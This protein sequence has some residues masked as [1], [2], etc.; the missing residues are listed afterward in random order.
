M[1]TGALALFLFLLALAGAAEA[2]CPIVYNGVSYAC[3][4]TSET[5]SGGVSHFNANA[6]ERY[7]Q[8]L[9]DGKEDVLEVGGGTAKIF[10]EY[11]GAAQ[12]GQ[13]TIFEDLDATSITMIH[14]LDTNPTYSQSWALASNIT[15]SPCVNTQW[16][17]RVT[18]HNPSP[19]GVD[20]I[21]I[22]GTTN[23]KVAAQYY[24][25]WASQQ[26]WY[27]SHGALAGIALGRVINCSTTTY[28]YYD[29]NLDGIPAMFAPK[30]VG[31]LMT[32]YRTST[33]DVNYP[34]YT[35]SGG[36]NCPAWL[37]S[38]KNTTSIGLP[39]FNMALWDTT[40]SGYNAANMCLDSGGSPTVY[41][42]N[43]RYVDPLLSSWTTTLRTAF[44]ALQATDTSTSR[45]V[46]LDVG[47]ATDSQVCYYSGTPSYT[48][49]IT[50]MKNVAAA[51]TDKIVM[52]EAGGEQFIPYADIFYL[53]AVGTTA[54]TTLPTTIGL[55]G[56]IYGSIPNLYLVGMEGGPGDRESDYYRLQYQG[57]NV[58]YRGAMFSTAGA[59]NEVLWA[60][61]PTTS[62]ARLCEVG[63]R[64][65]CPD[66]PRS[67]AAARTPR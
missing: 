41:G 27:H 35:C 66:A 59:E 11:P 65:R 47:T 5:V 43:L 63:W 4:V 22:T 29:T 42:G 7:A 2:T 67:A 64:N 33:F 53:Y 60:Q 10:N 20:K 16:C 61:L 62:Y 9:Y 32:Q 14:V 58:F 6:F 46:Y 55:W 3:T 51:F 12:W 24:K 15:T 52:F 19:V 38:L 25:D 37:Q 45:G 44:D 40:H 54:S 13:L 8:P 57:R 34:D 18:Q 1:R 31:C 23:W 36:A 30:Q 39:Y 49:W 56:F 28:S 21:V 48:A 17:L 50:G 26:S